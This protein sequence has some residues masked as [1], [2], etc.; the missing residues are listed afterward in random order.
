MMYYIK[1][2]ILSLLIKMSCGSSKFKNCPFVPV[3]FNCETPVITL[4]DL[5]EHEQNFYYESSSS[6]CMKSAVPCSC[7]YIT[8][9]RERNIYMTL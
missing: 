4:G 7:K 3:P 6:T 9:V 5:I 2:K 1:M 8:S